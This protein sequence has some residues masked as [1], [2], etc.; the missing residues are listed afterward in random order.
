M[1]SDRTQL[2]VSYCSMTH[3]PLIHHDLSLFRKIL[4]AIR[5]AQGIRS[6]F[7]TAILPIKISRVFCEPST[8][9]IYIGTASLKWEIQEIN[10]KNSCW[11]KCSMLILSA[12]ILSASTFL[13]VKVP[14]LQISFLFV[15]LMKLVKGVMYLG[16]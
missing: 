4:E 14:Q 13:S 7:F 16:L 12:V 15:I 11:L 9:T 8:S 10:K 1:F 5:K 2:S 3:T 6:M